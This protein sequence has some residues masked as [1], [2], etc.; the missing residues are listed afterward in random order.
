[1]IPS[2][3]I[4]TCQLHNGICMG[5]GRTRSEIVE[6]Y[7]ASDARKLEILDR[8]F[9]DEEETEAEAQAYA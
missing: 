7:T 4:A 1:M 8:I 6:W 9:Y 5:C 2:P 3:C